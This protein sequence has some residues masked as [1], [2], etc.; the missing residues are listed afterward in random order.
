MNAT[1]RFFYDHA[2]FSYD[3][4]TETSEQGHARCAREL[5]QA[6][7]EGKRRGWIVEAFPDDLPVMDDDVGSRELVESGQAVN[8]QV[9]LRAGPDCDPDEISDILGVL[10]GV[11]V[12]SE[13]DPYVR[14][15]GA[16]LALEALESLTQLL[17]HCDRLVSLESP[18][19]R[20]RLS[21]RRKDRPC[22]SD[23]S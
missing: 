2:G 20:A 6:E 18:P 13:D 12:P 3:P 8:L 7:L 23:E 17:G 14:V 16:E 9:W 5:A 22:T 4:E 10:G 19:Q 1:E 21:S 15:V 11:V